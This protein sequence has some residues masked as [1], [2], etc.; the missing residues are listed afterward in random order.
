MLDGILVFGIPCF[1][2][3]FAK[4]IDIACKTQILL[5]HLLEETLNLVNAILYLLVHIC[6]L[7]IRLILEYGKS[8]MGTLQ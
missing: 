5:W 6:F 3:D 7:H 4:H 2:D 8:S 1:Q